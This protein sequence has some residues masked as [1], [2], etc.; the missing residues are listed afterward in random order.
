[1]KEKIGRTLTKVQSDIQKAPSPNIPTATSAGWGKPDCPHCGGLG[2]LRYDV[3]VG[4]AKFG[5]VEVCVCRST[6]VVN[7]ARD[8]LY[9]LSD[10]ERL[11][12]LTFENFRPNGNKQ[13]K[14]ITPQESESLHEALQIC[15]DFVAKR[16]GWILLEGGY[17][18]GKTH[19]AAA[20]ANDAVQR[21]VA[22]LFITVPDL[23]DSLRIAYRS[24]ETTFEERFDDIRG[25][26]LLIMDDFGTQ[27]AT[28]WAQEKLFQIINHR[29]INK[30]PTVITT[31]LVLDEI[32]SR[33]RSR[34]QDG[35]LVRHVRISAPDY[36]RPEDTSNPGIS[37][38][39]LPD[40]KAMTLGNFSTRDDEAGREIVTTI[41]KERQ[42][43]FGKP[44]RDKEIVRE[45]VTPQH[46][47]QLKSAHNAAIEFAEKP[48]GWLVL[49][50]QSHCGK[51][52]LAAAIGN[53]R[54]KSGGQVILAGV[55][56]LLDY[57]K[58]TFRPN[59]DV[60]FDRRFYEIQTTPLLMLDDLKD[61]GTSSTWAEDKLHQILNHRYYSNLPTVI[62][63]TLDPESFA[64]GYPS[65]WNKILDAKKC[66][67]FVIDMPPYRPVAKAGKG[68]KKSAR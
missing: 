3:P 67:L 46:I 55:S 30:L 48:E 36:R 21:G 4:H 18:C 37:M 44:Y 54:L 25:A 65:L 49:L 20:I 9:A 62:T 50:G 64:K 34:L 19:L 41:V 2:Y 51:T 24:Q 17:G 42:D 58:T 35:D 14:F 43:R 31:N 16:S 60:S 33:I 38:L 32:E 47:K 8:R 12:H 59:S 66:Q 5:R 61:G 53:Y 15:M 57:L 63:S 1:M 13:A 39:S 22:T 56:D 11:S 28:A 7:N 23:L 52:H 40:I 26:E 45:K 10:L 6:E 68:G 29:Y 27:N